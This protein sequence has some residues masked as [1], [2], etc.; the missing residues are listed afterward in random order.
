MTAPNLTKHHK[1][2]PSRYFDQD[3]RQIDGTVTLLYH[4]QDVIYEHSVR[5]NRRVSRGERGARR[6]RKGNLLMPKVHLGINACFAVKRW[7]EPEDWIRMIGEDLH[8]G[9]AQ[10]STDLFPL[11]LGSNAAADYAD[12]VR[13]AAESKGVQIHSMFTG[14]GA[15]ASNLLLAESE[16][17][18]SAAYAWYQDVIRLA[19]RSGA[20]GAGGHVGAFSV[21]AFGDEALRQKLLSDEIEAMKRLAEFASSVGLD[22]L[23]FENLAVAREPGHS[24][25]EAMWFEE[26]LGACDIPW[27]LCLD[28]G[29]PVALAQNDALDVLDPWLETKWRN[30]PVIQL[31]QSTFGSDQHGPFTPRANESGGVDRDRV[32]TYLESWTADDI[33]LFL[34]FIPHHEGDDDLVVEEL[35]ESVEFWRD[36]IAR[37]SFEHA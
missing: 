9:V 5:S 25:D 13:R 33:Y 19:A 2:I 22:H 20:R 10:V 11:S 12:E 37:H 4:N 34:E 18:R 28:L 27:V 26:Q 21:R 35:T 30:T 24:L 36:G 23:Q 14:L 15:Y 7:S 8:L 31:Q 16:R 6:R 1:L 17:D 29:H 3:S 32:L